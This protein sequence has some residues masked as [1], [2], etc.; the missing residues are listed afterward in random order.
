MIIIFKNKVLTFN[1][2]KIDPSIAVS[3][4][5]RTPSSYRLVS[6]SSDNK[7]KSD[8]NIINTG[9]GDVSSSATVES[10]IQ[11][12]VS[13]Q[14]NINSTVIDN[15]TQSP[16]VPNN[17][18][19]SS[20]NPNSNDSSTNQ[21]NLNNI[22]NITSQ[23]NTNAQN[24]P[25]VSEQHVSTENERTNFSHDS[26][27]LGS[28][29]LT[30][31]LTVISDSNELQNIADKRFNVYVINKG[32]YMVPKSNFDHFKTSSAKEIFVQVTKYIPYKILEWSQLLKY[33][34]ESI[35]L[36]IHGLKPLPMPYLQNLNNVLYSN[37][38]L[39]PSPAANMIRSYGYILPKIA[40]AYAN[41]LYDLILFLSSKFNKLSVEYEFNSPGGLA[42]HKITLTWSYVD[43]LGKDRQK[44]LTFNL[45]NGSY[46]TSSLSPDFEFSEK[47]SMFYKKSYVKMFREF[48]TFSVNEVQFDPYQVSTSTRQAVM[49][50]GSDSTSILDGFVSRIMLND[51]VSFDF[52]NFYFIN[53]LLGIMSIEHLGIKEEDFSEK[54]PII[55]DLA[56]YLSTVIKQFILSQVIP[57]NTKA[58]KIKLSCVLSRNKSYRTQPELSEA[59]K[60][61]VKRGD[62]CPIAPV[63][64]SSYFCKDTPTNF[65]E[66]IVLSAI[67]NVPL[68]AELNSL[69]PVINI[70]SKQ[71]FSKYT[72]DK[73]TLN[74]KFYTNVPIPAPHNNVAVVM[75]FDEFLVELF[76]RTFL[77]TVVPEYFPLISRGEWK[78]VQGGSLV[79]IPANLNPV[80][81]KFKISD[82][83]NLFEKFLSNITMRCD[84][85]VIP[86]H[87]KSMTRLTEF[88]PDIFSR[89]VLEDENSTAFI[90]EIEAPE[91]ISYMDGIDSEDLLCDKNVIEKV[92]EVIAE[93]ADT[94]DKP[95]DGVK[96]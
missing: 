93:N 14:S 33:Y 60:N 8:L 71:S 62:L 16:E 92:E 30:S 35:F 79:V 38:S 77:M 19:S 68:N 89:F 6:G 27:S 73:S 52:S 45:D 66:F 87:I 75:T 24:S 37:D 43:D 22:N 63:H 20:V 32:T 53:T 65:S 76:V 91:D 7:I 70:N 44:R 85:Y 36:V 96:K 72:G 84:K 51:S 18:T 4:S 94:S 12:R 17:T 78:G 81:V 42:S 25:N 49:I 26:E 69:L 15:N 47:Y 29:I 13:E 3:E 1:V 90:S 11:S 88:C 55:I 34:T 5:F 58:S 83:E 9:A 2:K 50:K 54:N 48:L 64:F 31:N 82:F 95:D 59:M 74:I 86:S 80:L 56:R 40:Y 21:Q 10:Q 23:S 46:E 39:K 61:S 28:R 57:S 67:S 41:G